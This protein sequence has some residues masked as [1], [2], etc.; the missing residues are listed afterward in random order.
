[1]KI[2]AY[3]SGGRSEI[4]AGGFDGPWRF[5]RYHPA[6]PADGCRTCARIAPAQCSDHRPV[7]ERCMIL[8]PGDLSLRCVGYSGNGPAR[9]EDPAWRA[10]DPRCG[11]CYLGTPHTIARHDHETA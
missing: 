2:Q 5:D 1:M 10:Y 3:T 11:S 9:P 8:G 4:A 7:M 6:P